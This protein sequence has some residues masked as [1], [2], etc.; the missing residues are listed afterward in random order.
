MERPLERR[1]AARTA[2]V[3]DAVRGVLGRLAE[4]GAACA[5]HRRRH[6]RLRGPAG[7]AR[8]PGHRRRPQPRRP[9]GAGPTGRRGGRRR[10]G[11]RPPGRPRRPRELAPRAARRPGALPRRARAGRRP[12]RR[13][14]DDRRRCCVP[15]APSRLLVSQQH[16]AVLARAMAGHLAQA[17][18]APRRDHVGPGSRPAGPRPSAGSPPTRSPACSGRPGFAVAAV[19]GVRVFS[20]LVPPTLL[21]LEPGAAPPCSSSSEPS[22]PARSTSTLAHPAPRPRH[23]GAL[24][25]GRRETPPGAPPVGHRQGLHGR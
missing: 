11:H 19:H 7:R 5:R 20:D 3:W 25:T 13:P 14:G 15:A 4:P 9:R 6:R 18:A 17:R 23:A 1:T 22:P 10:P 24:G 2:V 8:P 12:G 21:D 16:A